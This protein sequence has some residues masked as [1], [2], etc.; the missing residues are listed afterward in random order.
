MID[1]APRRSC[2]ESRPSR[3]IPLKTVRVIATAAAFA[4]APALLLALL[5]GA[6][7]ATADAAA[8]R[9]ADAAPT[10]SIFY[11]P[12]YGTPAL[13]GDYEH[14]QTAAQTAPEEIASNYYPASGLYSSS[15]PAVVAR[16]M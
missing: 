1:V 6:V 2:I 7:G 9:A 14:W 16:Q 11:Y 5:P 12:W 8:T 10:A 3:P 15:D 13:D 4:V